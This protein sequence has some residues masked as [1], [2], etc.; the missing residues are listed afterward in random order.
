MRYTLYCDGFDRLQ[1][2]RVAA[3][4][5][6]VQSSRFVP[7][8]L[9]IAMAAIIFSISDLDLVCKISFSDPLKFFTGNANFETPSGGAP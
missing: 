3:V 4:Q 2:F 5:K 9:N 1:V 6:K 8:E 7:E